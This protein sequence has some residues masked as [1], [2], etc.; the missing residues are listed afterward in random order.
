M[1]MTFATRYRAR[2]ILVAITV[3]TALV[4]LFSVL[5][6]AAIGAALP[7]GAI[8]VVAGVA[9]LT[10]AAWTLRGDELSLRK[11][12]H[13]R[14]GPSDRSSSPLAWLSCLPSWATRPCWALSLWPLTTVCSEPGSDRR[15]AWLQL[16][17]LAIVV[18]QQLGTRLPEQA[19]KIGAAITFAAFGILLIAEGLL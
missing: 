18:G 7:T 9:F 6:G 1:A 4:H 15:L 10:F 14:P 8:S 13:E 16:D 2:T 12:Q 3:A 17:A 5:V 11:T 19:I